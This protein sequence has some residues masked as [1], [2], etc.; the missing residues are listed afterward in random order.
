[1]SKQLIKDGQLIADD[2]WQTV[3]IGDDA[4]ADDA[5]ALVIPAGRVVIPAPAWLAQRDNLLTRTEHLHDIAVSLAP[6]FRVE[7][8]AHDVHRFALIAVEFPKFIDGRGYST[9]RLLRER[10]AYQGELRAVGNIGRDQLF[11]LRRV[12]FNAFLLPPEQNAEEA[13]Q[14]LNDFPE[15]YQGAVDQPLPLFRRRTA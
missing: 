13:L 12:G 8:I 15:V 1:M 5:A 11:Y 3:L 14:S 2:N 9:A 10:Y 7:D 6:T 4:T